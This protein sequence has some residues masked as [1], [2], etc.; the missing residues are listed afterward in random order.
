MDFARFIPWLALNHQ[1][2][3]VLIH[4]Q[5]GDDYVDH[6]TH[7]LWLGEK[8]PLDMGLFDQPKFLAHD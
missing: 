1:S 6:S 2:L 5:T 7:A 3:S 8:V 4:P